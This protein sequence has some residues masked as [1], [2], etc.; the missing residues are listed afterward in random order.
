MKKFYLGV[1][2]LLSFSASFGQAFDYSPSQTLHTELEYDTYSIVDIYMQ[3][4]DLSGITFAWE[5]VENTIPEEWDY[6]LCDYTACFSGIP[7]DGIMTPI[8]DAE[9]ADGTKGFLKITITP[10]EFFGTGN[11]KFYVYNQADETEGDTIEFTFS[12]TGGVGLEEEVTGLSL[13]PNPA[14]ETLVLTNGSNVDLTYSVLD[15]SGKLISMG[16]VNADSKETVDVS[17]L[18]PGIYFLRTEQN[19]TAILTE[20]IVIQ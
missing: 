3:T 11:V 2:A 12:L 1:C 6:S 7:D 9:M 18:Q 10:N 8:A 4:T 15:L 20:K 13:Y 16:Y 17:A 5:T 19:G 14:S